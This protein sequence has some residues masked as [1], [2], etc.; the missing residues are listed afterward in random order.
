MRTITQWDTLLRSV[1]WHGAVWCAMVWRGSLEH[2]ITCSGV[3]HMHG[4]VYAAVPEL[5][6][7]QAAAAAPLPPA[8]AA[9]AAPAAA[10]PPAAAPAAAAVHSIGH[11]YTRTHRSSCAGQK[12]GMLKKEAGFVVFLGTSQV[13]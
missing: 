11:D 1:K 7:R 13:L 5:S 12:A 10:P 6:R 8:P 3:G 4:I 2:G 9:A